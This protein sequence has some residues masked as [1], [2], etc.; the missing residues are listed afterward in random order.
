MGVKKLMVESRTYIFVFA[1]LFLYGC[2]SGSDNPGTQT[3]AVAQNNDTSRVVITEPQ[4]G[5]NISIIENM[6]DAQTNRRTDILNYTDSFLQLNYPDDWTLDNS[7]PDISAQF[8]TPGI[9]E[10]GGRN[11]CTLISSFEPGRSLLLVIQEIFDFLDQNP[12]PVTSFINVNGTDMARIDGNVT[13]QGVVLALNTQTA[14]EDEYVHSIFCF[15]I[16]AEDIDL[17]FGSMEIF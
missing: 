2:S 13:M 3:T 14:Y 15:G 9:N 12:E 17:V 6:D 11:A 1:A 8:L 7:D 5:N 10:L 4:P 16:S